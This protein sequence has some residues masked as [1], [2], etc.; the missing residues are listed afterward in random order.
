M[1]ICLTK[2]IPRLCPF[3]LKAL[4]FHSQMALSVLKREQQKP[5]VGPTTLLSYAQANTGS[6]VMMLFPTDPHNLE[7]LSV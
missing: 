6:S 4:V 1:A 5:A 7:K 3:E 2:Y